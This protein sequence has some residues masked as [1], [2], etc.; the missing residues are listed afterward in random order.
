MSHAEFQLQK[1]VCQL[2][3]AAY[4]AVLYAAIP[5]GAVLCATDDPVGRQR[6]KREIS[7]LKVTGMRSGI[8]DLALWW[9][10][11]G[12]G[13]IE[14]KSPDGRVSPEQRAVIN[15]LSDLGTWVAVC[16]SIDDVRLVLDAWG[17]PTIARAA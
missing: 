15:R 13:L 6:A 17:V 3:D 1:S 9:E 2:L 16:R 11:G 10:S 12:H 7:K 14:L 8:P 5:N 4:P